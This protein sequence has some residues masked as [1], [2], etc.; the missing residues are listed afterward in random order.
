MVE[1]KEL[2]TVIVPV[3]KVEKYLSRCVES[4]LNQ[5]YQNIEI[6][7]IDDDSPD[8]C[9]QICD[10][11]AKDYPNIKSI[12]LKNS[13]IGVSDAR[14]TGLNN[15]KGD[16]IAFVDSDDYIHRD[17]FLKLICAI[18]KNPEVNL[19][20][21]SYQKIT[22]DTQIDESSLPSTDVIFLNDMGAM[23]LIIEDQNMT[24][25]WSKL[26][27]RSVFE[28][29]RFPTGKH[30]EDMFLMPFILQEASKIAYSPLPLY[31]YYQDNE[32][33]C[34]S[35]FNYNMLDMLEA[36][37]GWNKFVAVKYP[38]L[39]KK[40][41]SHYYT[42]VLNS[43]QYLANK[44]DSIGVERFEY[45]QSEINAEFSI[46][47]K[48]KFLSASNKLKLILLKIKLFKLFFCLLN[49]LNIKIYE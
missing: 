4:I 47:I 6:L 29:L 31:Y 42:S 39:L 22:G 25:V 27:R 5:T 35:K 32:S 8:N 48:S 40:V 14:N 1:G 41:K 26:Y 38:S 23:N 46:L 33:L 13:G 44:K 49:R 3:Y 11:Y 19:A 18:E 16:Y 17:L 20:I 30:N 43:C 9:P 24:A 2:I 37:N 10:A 7:L 34:R 36:L 12:H 21:A 45:Y 28:N 15:A